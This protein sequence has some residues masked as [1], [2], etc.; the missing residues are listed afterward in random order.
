[1][2]EIAPNINP[3]QSPKIS[4]LLR[5]DDVFDDFHQLYFSPV[6]Y[7]LF[8]KGHKMTAKHF[9]AADVLP[10]DVLNSL[11]GDLGKYLQAGF[12]NIK[13]VVPGFLHSENLFFLESR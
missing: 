11:A 2:P 8:R 10:C 5:L 4:K 9:K 6:E 12:V 1:M 3:P 7:H 13:C